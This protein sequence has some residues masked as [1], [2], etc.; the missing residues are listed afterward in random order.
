MII[1]FSSLTACQTN[2]RLNILFIAVDDLR[3]ELGCYG[4]NHIISPNID[5][6]AIEGVRFSNSRCNIPVCGASRASLMT[7]IRPE[8]NRFVNYQT[9]ADK[10]FPGHLSLPRY[11]KQN[12]YHTVSLGKVYHHLMDDKN[13]WSEEPWFPQGPWKGWQAYLEKSS[14]DLIKANPREGQPDRIAGPAWEIGDVADNEYPDGMI[15]DRAMEEL[16]RVATLGQPFFLAVGFLK[17]HLPFNA[18]RKYWDL[19]DHESIDLASNPF[20]PENAPRESIHNSGELRSGYINVPEET[21]LP[22]EYARWLIHGYYACVSYTD[23]QIGKLLDRLED[24]GLAENTIVILWG[25]HGWNLGEHTMW[26]KHCNYD[27]S[28][29][30]PILIKAPGISGDKVSEALVEY[31]DIYPSLV[32]LCGLPIPEHCQGTS[33]VP[34]MKNPEMAWKKATFSRWIKGD[35]I[36]TERFQYTEWREEENGPVTARMMYDHQND[37]HENINIAD[38]PRY[39]EEALRL[40]EMLQEGWRPH[41]SQDR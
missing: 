27:T 23:A 1:V 35:T 30:A 15:A 6:I 17:P 37:P 36:T 11:L 8:W 10:D 7:G 2:E 21:P 5:R 33:F 28:L 41:N 3:P 13:A 12:G 18:P 22:D 20:I 38:D 26:C 31:V 32:E 9:W 29:R 16:D 19:Y 14:L 25:D 4:G 34:L 24:H 39:Q 40:A